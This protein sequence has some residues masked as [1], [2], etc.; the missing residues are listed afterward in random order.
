ML[1]T[2]GFWSIV[3]Y[4]CYKFI[5]NIA[6]ILFTPFA[7]YLIF[8]SVFDIYLLAILIRANYCQFKINPWDIFICFL[9]NYLLSNLHWQNTSLI[10]IMVWLLFV[11]LLS[12]S[13]GVAV[14]T[15]IS[16]AL[17]TLNLSASRFHHNNWH[18]TFWIRTTLCTILHIE[19]I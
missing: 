7:G 18:S 1:S 5:A 4:I 14:P 19:L 9:W 11:V 16:K 15:E 3:R 2:I 13:N 8:C 6:K 10:W 12:F 17:C